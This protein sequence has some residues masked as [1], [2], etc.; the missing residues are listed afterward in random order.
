VASTHGGE[1]VTEQPKKK[2][3]IFRWV[4]LA[5]Q[6]LFLIWIIAGGSGA[7]DNCDGKVGDALSACQAGTA[8]GAG[9]GIA[10]IIGLWVAVDI[11]LGITYL[12]VRKK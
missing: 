11:I 7:A 3:H 12:I 5:V 6:A 10:L 8:V 9:I 4:F 1:A 2:R